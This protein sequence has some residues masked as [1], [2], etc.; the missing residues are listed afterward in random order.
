MRKHLLVGSAFALATILTGAVHAQPAGAP[1]AVPADPVPAAPP[2][3]T[4]TAAAPAPVAGDV[5][6]GFG[7]LGQIAISGDLQ[8]TFTHES[9]SVPAG[10]APPST[11][12]ISIQPS[13][14]YFVAPN[15]SVGGAIPITH[16]DLG[17]V[18][19]ATGIGLLARG[20]YNL[21]LAPMLS[22]WPQLSIGYVHLSVSPT[23][24]GSSV[25]GY[26]VPLRIFVPLLIHP[27][28]HFFVGIGPVFQTDLISKVSGNDADKTTDVGVASV[29]GGYFGS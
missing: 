1:P 12:T 6:A 17:G 24:G 8:A 13:L 18:G 27:T 3:P 10:T 14:D 9:T 15:I 2:P 7:Q 28:E 5:A 21:H 29:V 19:T 16:G 20:G 4:A 22:L 23:G 25:S 26:N 11:N